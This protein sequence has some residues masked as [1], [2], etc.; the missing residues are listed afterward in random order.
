M[1]YDRKVQ[2]YAGKIAGE[3]GVTASLGIDAGE[4]E[5]NLET[6][7]GICRFLMSCGADRDA[8][9]LAVGGGT[10][11]D[12]AG[13]AAALYKRG[14]SV[15]F[16][17]TTLLSM[18][19]AAYGGKNGVNLD[20]YKNM[21]G[22]FLQPE[23][24]YRDISCLATLPRR[25]FLSGA[26]ELLKTFLIGDASL[27]AE[28]VDV[29]RRED[30]DWRHLDELVG[31]AVAIKLRIVN[32]DP[33][34]NGERHKLNLGHT[35]AHAIEWY[36]HQR[37]VECPLTHGEAVAIGII[38]SASL[39]NESLAGRLRS[40]F[41]ACGLPVDLPYPLD[42]LMPAM[43]NDKKNGEGEIRFVL[44]HDIADITY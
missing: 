19:D 34:D 4:A 18:V 29:L 15:A 31:Q 44:I 20:C 2:E 1:V 3:C 40:D 16:V 12:V 11:T 24:V 8:L 17:P 38:Q 33:Y 26:A 23:F 13:L 39:C 21:V 37:G 41:R 6:V 36:E 7:A 14:I 32:A 43:E 22:T 28:T 10:V 27:Y 35:F 25:E 9:L 30:I 5:K 42:E